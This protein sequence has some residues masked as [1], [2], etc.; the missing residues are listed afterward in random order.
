MLKGQKHR[1]NLHDRSFVIFFDHFEIT[2]VQK[3]L[4]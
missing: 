1:P 3:I 4:S 2:L